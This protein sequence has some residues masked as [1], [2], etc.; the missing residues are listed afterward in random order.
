MLETERRQGKR[1]PINTG[2]TCFIYYN[3]NHLAFI[4][5]IQAPTW[6]Y[7][8]TNTYIPENNTILLIQK[9]SFFRTIWVVG[10]IISCKK[11]DTDSYV[12][13]LHI[14]YIKQQD[15]KKIQKSVER[16]NASKK[17]HKSKL[18]KGFS[19]GK[20]KKLISSNIVN[21]YNWEVEIKDIGIKGMRITTR[22]RIE[23]C[24]EIQLM[25]MLPNMEYIMLSGKILWNKEVQKHKYEY[26]V[27]FV[28]L[29]KR[30]Q[31]KISE[32]VD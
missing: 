19:N 12:I 7:L 26:G 8:E 3:S 27:Q 20:T 5:S 4:T 1:K 10:K 24:E 31:E 32:Y 16:F 29:S 15:L 25:F 23:V 21:Y 9:L 30:V 28:K 6:I 11:A 13:N 17:L 2:A 22:Q 18:K 14:E